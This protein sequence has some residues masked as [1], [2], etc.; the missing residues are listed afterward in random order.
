VQDTG[1]SRHIPCGEGLWAFDD[2]EMAASALDQVERDYQRQCRAA[3]EIAA[4]YFDSSKVLNSLLER[5][6]STSDAQTGKEP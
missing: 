3:R 5:A 4:E 1:F 2:V 6:F